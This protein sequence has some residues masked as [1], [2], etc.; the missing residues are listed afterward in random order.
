MKQM[1]WIGWTCWAV[2]GVSAAV[3][4]WALFWDRAQGRLRC[5]KCAYDMSGGGLTCPECGREHKSK[6]TLKRTRRRW[7]TAV[8]AVVIGGFA[9][10]P[11]FRRDLVEQEGA[12]GLVPTFVLAVLCDP[13][14]YLTNSWAGQ[15]RLTSVFSCRIDNSLGLR[16]THRF[17]ASRVQRTWRVTP[18]VIQDDLVVRIY[19]L[20]DIVPIGSEVEKWYGMNCFGPYGKVNTRLRRCNRDTW[21]FVTC[22][23]EHEYFLS[24]NPDSPSYGTSCLVGDQWVQGAEAASHD[25]IER[26]LSDLTNN[27]WCVGDAPVAMGMPRQHCFVVYELGLDIEQP[28]WDL[29]RQ[30]WTIVEYLEKSVSP[31][32]WTNCG[33]LEATVLFAVSGNVFIWA[34]PEHHLDIMKH[35]NSTEA[36]AL[37]GDLGS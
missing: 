2:I 3:S 18:P 33:G 4:L 17:W 24:G 37:L 14:D 35:L 1:D 10:Y 15:S 16:A 26:C 21:E 27:H 7:N 12:W 31:D 19:D 36:A 32:L 11:S 34:S 23:R 6:K 5:R 25:F 28:E 29:S 13:E 9:L 20:S 30:I 22:L 8:V